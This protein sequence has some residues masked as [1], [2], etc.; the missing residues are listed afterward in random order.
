MKKHALCARRH[1]GIRGKVDILS[2]NLR[3]NCDRYF[4]NVP[5]LSSY[6]GTHMGSTSFWT[7]GQP[8][9]IFF[10]HTKSFFFSNFERSL[11]T[12]DRARILAGCHFSPAVRDEAIHLTVKL[13]VSFLHHLRALVSAQFPPCFDD[14]KAE[15]QENNIN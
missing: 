1:S 7:N 13:V 15:Y 10:S 14:E 4:S 6:N 2:R 9:F 8:T 5:S 11:K 12:F 3:A